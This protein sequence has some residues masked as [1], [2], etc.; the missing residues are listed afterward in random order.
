MKKF[1]RNIWRYKAL[2]IMALP[3]AIWMIFFFYIPVLQMW[4]LLKIFILIQMDF[5][6]V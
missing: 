2:I 1:F 4:W 5:W 3:G 6:P